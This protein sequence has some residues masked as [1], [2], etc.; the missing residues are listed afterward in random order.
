M[1]LVCFKNKFA[2]FIWKGFVL[3]KGGIN[4]RIAWKYYKY[5]LSLVSCFG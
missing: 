5:M 4:G 2:Y 1:T 3:L